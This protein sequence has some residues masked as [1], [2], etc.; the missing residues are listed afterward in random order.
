MLSEII[1]Q[2]H[3]G[4]FPRPR[5]YDPKHRHTNQSMQS[6]GGPEKYSITLAQRSKYG[7]QSRKAQIVD[8]DANPR[9]VWGF[10]TP[11]LPGGDAEGLQSD[12]QYARRT[13]SGLT[14]P[15]AQQQ[16]DDIG[17]CDKERDAGQNLTDC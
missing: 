6:H 7:Q 10:L 9:G 8:A 14:Q 16:S 2:S 17:R 1:G 3:F 11:R 12:P 4:I 15:V 5:Y 13:S